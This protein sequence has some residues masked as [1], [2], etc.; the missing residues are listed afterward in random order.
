[1][2]KYW[3]IFRGDNDW[4]VVNTVPKKGVDLLDIKKSQKEVLHGIMTRM[5]EA[6]EEG[7]FGAVMTEDKNTHGC[8]LVCWVAEPYALQE[9]TDM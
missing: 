3:D 7:N 1:M 9:E 6:I 2:C 8:Y 4:I 5:A